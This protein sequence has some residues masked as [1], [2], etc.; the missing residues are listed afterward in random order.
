MLAVIDKDRAREL[1]KGQAQPPPAC[2]SGMASRL[3][4]DAPGAYDIVFLERNV[5]T[6]VDVACESTGQRIPLVKQ[7]PDRRDQLLMSAVWATV[8]VRQ[9][10]RAGCPSFD[11]LVTRVARYL[12]P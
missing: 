11:R 4:E 1:W 9:A 8:P 2:M 10:I 7:R 3:H 5:D 12:R 6:L